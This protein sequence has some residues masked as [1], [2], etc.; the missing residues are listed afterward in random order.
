MP[1]NPY[2]SPEECGAKPAGQTINWWKAVCLVGG[3][4]VAVGTLGIY[5]IEVGGPWYANQR[6]LADWTALVCY[7]LCIVAAEVGAGV[8]ALAGIGWLMR[9]LWRRSHARHSRDRRPQRGRLLAFSQPS[10]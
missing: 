5:S 8:C 1:P 2:Q 9:V 6:T 3:G 4:A 7:G 10:E